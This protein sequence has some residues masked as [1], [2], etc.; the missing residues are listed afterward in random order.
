LRWL[1][2]VLQY[3]H[4]NRKQQMTINTT[5]VKFLGNKA[6]MFQVCKG[7]EVVQVFCTREEAQA[8]IEAQ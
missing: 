6:Q 3:I 8:W 5:T 4:T 7:N 1:I 2:S